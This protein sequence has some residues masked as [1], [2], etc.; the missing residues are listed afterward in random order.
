MGWRDV[1]TRSW[2][3]PTVACLAM[4][5]CY[6]PDAGTISAERDV[7]GRL[8]RAPADAARVPVKGS[9]KAPDY[10]DVTPRSRRTEA[11]P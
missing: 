11:R 4:A 3:M 9:R 1:V 10:N 2:M 6:D 7:A 5:G 8:G